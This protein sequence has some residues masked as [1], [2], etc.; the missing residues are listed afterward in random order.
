[1]K[2][3]AVGA[4]AVAGSAL[5]VAPSVTAQAVSSVEYLSTV[6]VATVLLGVGITVRANEER[7]FQAAQRAHFKR[8][9]WHPGWKGIQNADG[10][11]K[12]PAQTPQ[13][14]VALSWCRTYNLSPVIVTGYG[15]PTTGIPGFVVA[16]AV[17]A[18][19]RVIPLVPDANIPRILAR[20]SYVRRTGPVASQLVPEGKWSYDGGLIFAVDAAAPSITL[21]YPT[22]VALAAGDVLR[23]EVLLYPPAASN[24]PDDPSVVAFTNYTR[25][26]AK[27]IASAGTGGD[28]EGWNEPPWA[29]DP[30]DREFDYYAAGTAPPDAK[31]LAGSMNTGFVNRMLRDWTPEGGAGYIFSGP[32]KSG[33]NSIYGGRNANPELLTKANAQRIA[34][35]E[36]FHPY[37]DTPEWHGWR[38]SCLRT[39]PESG[40]EAAC[41]L[42][43]VNQTSNFKTAVRWAMNAGTR[44]GW[45]VPQIITEIGAGGFTDEDKKGRHY[46]RTLA[47][48]MGMGLTQV[49]FFQ[50][51]DPPGAT[52]F[53]D[54]SNG[55]YREMRQFG[56]MRDFLADLAAF[57]VGVNSSTALPGVGSYSGTFPL[58]ATPFIARRSLTQAKN[59][60]LLML[61]QRTYPAVGQKWYDIPAVTPANAT[62]TAPTGYAIAG[63]TDLITR[64]PVAMQGQGAARTLPVGDNPIL[65]R[66][67]FG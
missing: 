42:V 62:V 46:L 23:V 15:A 32:H 10:T 49:I 4:L 59:D 21:A 47:A 60:V 66:V 17:P 45:A 5:A 54:R 6:P 18:G 64:Q 40:I 37:G 24:S 38:P 33:Y 25:H 41:A 8:V 1:M 48:Y 29:H 20:K 2:R 36:A 43:G 58:M 34:L 28:V 53:I 61:W 14:D 63:A 11:F 27:R 50:M 51:S 56:I 55:Q 12:P 13:L 39:A 35:K 31:Q 16:S 67:L 26:V 52:A 57:P 9:R 19:Q 30:W 65:V 3:R 44:N 22:S 7:E